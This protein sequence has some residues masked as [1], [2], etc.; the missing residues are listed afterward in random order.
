MANKVAKIIA[1]MI[2][3]TSIALVIIVVV[4]LKMYY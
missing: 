1:E 2:Y 4:R 3:I